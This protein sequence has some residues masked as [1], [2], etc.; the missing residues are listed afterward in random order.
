[1]EVS[2]RSNSVSHCTNKFFQVLAKKIQSRKKIYDRIYIA[3]AGIAAS[4]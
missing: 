4:E 2:S 3:L 1:M